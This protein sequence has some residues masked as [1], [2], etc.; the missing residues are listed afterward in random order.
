MKSTARTF[1]TLALVVCLDAT[2]ETYS[3]A[4][5]LE[6]YGRPGEVEQQIFS[7]RGNAFVLNS[8]FQ[9]DSEEKIAEE[10]TTDIVLTSI[11]Q[12][13]ND[14]SIVVTVINKKTLRFTQAYLDASPPERLPRVIGG[15]CVR[16][17]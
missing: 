6:R 9:Q 7:R 10:S 13:H 8:K 11:V 16:S 14:M 12:A 15:K 1:A 3:C 5:E 4:A 17:K 2:A